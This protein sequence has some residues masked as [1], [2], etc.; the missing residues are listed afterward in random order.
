[1][2]PCRPQKDVRLRTKAST[3]AAKIQSFIP[4][5]LIVVSLAYG[6]RATT[7]LD[8]D[9]PA[10][11]GLTQSD[12]YLM[13]TEQCKVESRRSS[14]ADGLDRL[15]CVRPCGA[16]D[17][18]SSCTDSVILSVEIERHRFAPW[19]QLAA[20]GEDGFRGGSGGPNRWW[21]RDA[22]SQSS[23]WQPNR[24]SEAAKIP[25]GTGSLFGELVRRPEPHDYTARGV[26]SHFYS[27]HMQTSFWT[28]GY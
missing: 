27:I 4:A 6:V 23:Q 12:R 8:S 10:S 15:D 7:N 13:H 14:R 22:S 20:R 28:K 26:G 16:G 2:V 11:L 17:G 1:M 3:V 25:E 24:G 18:Y 9:R 21:D 5:G 19:A